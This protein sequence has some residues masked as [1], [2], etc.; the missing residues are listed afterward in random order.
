MTEEPVKNLNKKLVG[1]ISSD[2]RTYITQKRDCLTIIT[3]NHDG[4]L[5]IMHQYVKRMQNKHVSNK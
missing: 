4:T 5:H 1:K 3:A 2:H